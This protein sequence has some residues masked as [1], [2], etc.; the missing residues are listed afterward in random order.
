MSS[1]KIHQETN[2][3]SF[4]K[5]EKSTTVK[6]EKEGADGKDEKDKKEKEPEFEMLQNPSRV[7]KP[8]VCDCILLL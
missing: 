1:L 7:I 8:Q 6:S 2:C 3:I 4:K 5:D